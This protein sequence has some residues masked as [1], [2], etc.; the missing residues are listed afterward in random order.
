MSRTIEGRI[1]QVLS[2]AS[3]GVAVWAAFH[4]YPDLAAIM[5]A[6]IVAK[7]C[8]RSR[9]CSNVC[10]RKGEITGDVT[11]SEIP[12][13]GDTAI[14]AKRGTPYRGRTVVSSCC[15]Q[16]DG[17]A[18]THHVSRSQADAKICPRARNCRKKISYAAE[19]RGPILQRRE[20]RENSKKICARRRQQ[21][22][23]FPKKI[24]RRKISEEVFREA[25]LL[26]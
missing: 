14:P 26:I 24:S 7:P 11:A 5:V 1:D 16:S 8:R 13:A 15:R 19:N 21:E 4:G 23:A 2:S 25:L 6:I 22:R 18:C 10:G 20:E 3:A 12:R 17:Y 9:S